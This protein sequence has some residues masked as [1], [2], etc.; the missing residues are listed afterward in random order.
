MMPAFNEAPNRGASILSKGASDALMFYDLLV[1]V[2]DGFSGKLQKNSQY[3][4][5]L[6]SER[7]QRQLRHFSE[8][9]A[10]SRNNSTVEFQS[11]VDT[12]DIGD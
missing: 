4:C 9:R 3:R 5:L 7:V 12:E 8:N 6:A 1:W 2:L 10:P 11:G